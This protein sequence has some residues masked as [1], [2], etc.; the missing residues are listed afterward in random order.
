MLCTIVLT[1]GE[2][3]KA[4]PEP[5]EWVPLVVWNWRNK[6]NDELLKSTLVVAMV[7]S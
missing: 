5:L 7:D 4:V 3:H 1:P 6:W 2:N